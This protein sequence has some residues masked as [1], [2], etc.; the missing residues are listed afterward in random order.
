M[1]QKELDRLQTVGRF[2]NHQTS[3][4][5]DLQ[6]VLKLA[7][8]HCGTPAALIT[9]LDEDQQHIL[10][11]HGFDHDAIASPDA[12]CSHVIQ[13]DDVFLVPDASLDPRFVEH[14]LV[15]GGPKLRFYAGV[16]LTTKDGHKLGSFCVTGPEAKRLSGQQQ[17][18]LRVLA[19]QVI[20]LLEFEASI[21]IL[22]DRYRK[23]TK[24]ESSLRPFFQGSS[25]CMLLLDKELKIVAFNEALAEFSKKV[26]GIVPKVGMSINEHTHPD[27]ISTFFDCC[28]QALAGEHLTLE[29]LLEYGE[30]SIF[31]HI[32]YDPIPGPAGEIIG[33]SYTA[34]DISKSLE[35]EQ[36]IFLQNESLKQIAHVQSHQLR[37]PVSSILG[38][39]E[40]LKHDGHLEAIPEIA[41]MEQAVL[42][43]DDMIRKIVDYANTEDLNHQV[44][45]KELVQP[46]IS[47]EERQ[48]LA[49]LSRYNPYNVQFKV[50]FEDL[51][52]MASKI[53]GAEVAMI[54]FIDQDQQWSVSPYGVDIEPMDR[55][56]SIC[57]YTIQQE[58][59]LEVL[60]LSSDLRFAKL[61]AVREYEMEYYYG[62][63]IR[64]FDGQAIAALCVFSKSP[65]I[66]SKDQKD[67]L[68]LLSQQIIIRMDN[69]QKIEQLE[70]QLAQFLATTAQ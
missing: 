42:E 57:Q 11:Q 51:T 65:Q 68:Q 1:P 36:I 40:L 26:Y 15:T 49:A 32:T 60:S 12:F 25:S 54:N 10:F 39:M 62:V 22:K 44:A 8:D 35:H 19:R 43:L 18:T 63:P 55:S 5:Q 2:L 20:N 27:Y 14:P 4:E 69:M 37:K 30:H 21:K 23:V 6:D 28:K 61:P 59:E 33:V 3:K 52:R 66:L 53:S 64:T 13:Q 16:P 48:R 47:P 17:Q 29:R 70:G 56:L 31:W 50:T 34:T 24:S 58:S 45:H 9:L 67:M 7:A 41:V 46:V 38:L